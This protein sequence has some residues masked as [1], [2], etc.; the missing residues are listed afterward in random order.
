MYIEEKIDEQT[1]KLEQIEKKLDMVVATMSTII[2]M[3][4]SVKGAKD[5]N[6]GC[7]KSGPDTDKMFKEGELVEGDGEVTPPQGF[8]KLKDPLPTG[9]LDS[10]EDLIEKPAEEEKEVTI[11]EVKHA[12]MGLAKSKGKAAAKKALEAVDIASLQE[13]KPPQF[14]G[15]VS[16]CKQLAGA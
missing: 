15:I 16:A 2:A 6:P 7:A 8:I 9:E 11:E 5:A 10:F 14:A 4:K 3:D 12:L 13:A 1:K